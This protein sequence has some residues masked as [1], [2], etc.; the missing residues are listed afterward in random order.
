MTIGTKHKFKIACTYITVV[1]FR[2]IS[3]TAS[4]AKYSFV[5]YFGVAVL[6]ISST[7]LY[8]VAS[9]QGGNKIHFGGIWGL[10]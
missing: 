7:V 6:T 3:V 2:I 4:G 9:W 1:L 5:I 10:N 8:P